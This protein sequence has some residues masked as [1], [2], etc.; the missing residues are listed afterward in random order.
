MKILNFD[1]FTN[2]S[3]MQHLKGK[4]TDKIFK[5]PTINI[6]KYFKDYDNWNTSDEEVEKILS[7]IPEI[8]NI[9]SLHRE[10]VKK[11]NGNNFRITEPKLDR[12]FAEYSFLMVFSESE[13]F[14]IGIRYYDEM[15]EDNGDSY[16]YIDDFSRYLDIKD[17]NDLK[18]KTYRIINHK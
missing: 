4:G 12:D 15:D 8:I 18:R 6:L 7:G 14:N 1:N 10:I 13:K 11:Y 17:F 3:I 2:E 16:Y 9:R 5:N